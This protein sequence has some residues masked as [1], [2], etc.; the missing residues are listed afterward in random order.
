M[1]PLHGL[2]PSPTRPFGVLAIVAV[3]GAGFAAAWLGLLSV[4]PAGAATGI[5]SPSAWAAVA[6]SL[7]VQPQAPVLAANVIALW[8]FGGTVED[9]L[10]HGRFL[11]LWLA[12]G[13]AAGFAQAAIGHAP[14]ALAAAT[15]ATAAVIAAQLALYPRARILTATPVLVG[16]ELTDLPAWLYAAVWASVVVAATATKALAGTG[17]AVGAGLMVGAAAA[18]LLHRPE[19]MAVEWWGR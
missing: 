16:V 9:R 12:G 19:R 15:G 8:L 6:V 14:A 18:R 1:I 11:C 10:G 7:A 13:L 4:P 17:A 5:A 2:V 3:Q